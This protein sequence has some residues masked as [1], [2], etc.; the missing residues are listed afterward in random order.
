M[1]LASFIRNNKKTISEEWIKYA[2]KNI[3]ITEKMQKKEVK[4]HI[5]QMLD[6]IAWDIET[7]QT[8]QEQKV[9]SYGHKESL[10]S[11][12]MAS[13]EH[14]EQRVEVGFDIVELSSEF[15]ALRASVLR[16][17][18]ES[19][20][21]KPIDA[22]Q[23]QEMIRFNEAIDEAWMYSLEKYHT[24]F[25]E[26]KNWFLGILGHDLRNP[27]TAIAGVQSFLQMS[28]NLSDKEKEILKRTDASIKRM[29]ELINNLLDLT[30]LRLG[31][32]L[33]IDKSTGDLSQQCQQ[34]VQEFNLAYP[35]TDIEFTSPGPLEG[36]WDVLR[37]N[38]VI[39]NL[40]ANAMRHGKP[41]G[42]VKIRVATKDEEVSLSVHNKGP[43]IP[44]S[45]KHKIFNG[46]VT[47]DN[48][49]GL[50]QKNSYGLGLYI[51]HE[52]VERHNGRIEVESTDNAGTT[53]TVILPR[54]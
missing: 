18:E 9:K 19:M 29:E 5:L 53:F 42:P 49:N 28:S 24:T 8:K 51:V 7:S 1:G 10:E 32:G 25:N 34:I 11:Q 54:Y 15:R 20:H 27:L 39:T 46:M 43:K 52:I 21:S 23:F 37:I 47:G 35:E 12:N 17:W 14:G 2:K 6:R 26:S 13:I 36:K 40:I 3:S 4:D 48:G 16:L 30:K 38:Q 31:S 45:L 44:D 33:S 50:G 41:G 22:T